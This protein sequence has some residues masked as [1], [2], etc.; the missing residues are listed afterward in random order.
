MSTGGHVRKRGEGTWELKFDLGTDPLTGKRKTRY[1][2][3]KGTK[4]EA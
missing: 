2:N 4:P 1:H 3:F